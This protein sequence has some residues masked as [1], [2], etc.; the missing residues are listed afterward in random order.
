MISA[1]EEGYQ[2]LAPIGHN[3]NP[4]QFLVQVWKSSGDNP[5]VLTGMARIFLRVLLRGCQSHEQLSCTT[6]AIGR[7]KLALIASHG[8]MPSRQMGHRICTQVSSGV[9]IAMWQ[10]PWELPGAAATGR[11]SLWTDLGRAWFAALRA[12]PAGPSR[13]PGGSAKVRRITAEHPVVRREPLDRFSD[14]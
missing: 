14:V 3:W 5:D 4:D 7:Q 13:A 2:G 11:L 8:K 1:A 12:L 9:V 10:A 6:C